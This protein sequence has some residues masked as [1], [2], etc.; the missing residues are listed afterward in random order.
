[1]IK[2]LFYMLALPWVLSACS[3]DD[4][5]SQGAVEPR[6]VTPTEV[7]TVNVDVVLPASIQREW[8]NAFSWALENIELAQLQQEKRVRLN[9]RFHDEDTENMDSLAARLAKPEEGDDTCHAII[10]PYYND[11]AAIFLSYAAK[12]KL[13]VVMPTCTNTELH[14]IHALNDC[15]WFLTESD[16]SQCELML[17]AV[18][19]LDCKDVALLCSD[20]SYGQSFYDYFGF[21]ASEQDLHVAGQ[22]IAKYKKGDNLDAFFRSVATDTADRF[23]A[24][25]LLAFSNPDD[26]IDVVEQLTDFQER[27]FSNALI[28]TLSAGTALNEKTIKAFGKTGEIGLSPVGSTSNG[29]PQAYKARFLRDAYHGEAQVYDALTIIAMGAK[30][31]QSDPKESYLPG[32][33]FPENLKEKGSCFN[34]YM[35]ASIHEI[36]DGISTLWTRDGL[37]SAFRHLG[38]GKGVKALGAIGPLSFDGKTGT[39]TQDT[40]FMLWRAWEDTEKQGESEASA[41]SVLPICYL[42][43]RGGANSVNTRFLWE[44]TKRIQDFSD[45]DIAQHKL[46]DTADHWAVVISPSTSWNDYRHQADAFGMYQIL[47]IFGYDDEHIV[48]IVEDNLAYDERNPNPGDIYMENIAFQLP[49]E[50][51]HVFDV[52]KGAVVD[53]K[54]SQLQPDD[55]KDIMMGRRS[56]RLPHVISPDSASNVFFF[57]SGHGGKTDGPLWGGVDSKT[58]F[59]SQRIN[60]IVTSMNAENRYRRMLMTLETCFSGKWG[61]VLT[62]QPDLLVLTAAS[63]YETSKADS[64]S[65]ELGV[66]VSNA[67]TRAFRSEL[68]KFEDTSFYNLYMSLHKAT[69]GSHVSIY[70]EKN[71]GSVYSNSIGDYFPL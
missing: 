71:Y 60:D 18:R 30:Y 8:Q 58:Y 16:I 32:I 66:F 6:I 65:Q 2:Y 51:R 57:W 29:F 61:E 34:D 25:V 3:G 5:E 70:N 37:A 42:S 63:P 52:R 46:P 27:E 48:F 9:L 40:S 26:Y 49:A 35:R 44:L 4:D 15:A 41:V 59:G 1:M 50:H 14:R 19:S 67:F 54:F 20:D 13:P 62:G 36:N 28:M 33:Y 43:V 7:K 53:Y 12:P 31:Q 11:D 68:L 56:E 10:G 24:Y 55:L 21:F 64:F 47:K 17:T 22:G 39:K 38:E 69:N 45:E 23:F